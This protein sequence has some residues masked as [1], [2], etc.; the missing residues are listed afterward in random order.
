MKA[1]ELL[2]QM[3]SRENAL[4]FFLK[5]DYIEKLTN[6]QIFTL[7]N[8][9]ITLEYCEVNGQ[10]C[11]I[12][13]RAYFVIIPDEERNCIEILATVSNGDTRSLYFT[14]HGVQAEKMINND[15]VYSDV[16]DYMEIDE[17]ELDIKLFINVERM[18]REEF[19][20]RCVEIGRGFNKKGINEAFRSLVNY[21]VDSHKDFI[22]KGE[23]RD[24]EYIYNVIN[25]S[26][27]QSYQLEANKML[28]LIY[29]DYQ[30][31][32]IMDYKEKK[33]TKDFVNT[34]FFIGI[35]VLLVVLGSIYLEKFTNYFLKLDSSIERVKLLVFH[36]I[37]Y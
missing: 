14:L 23:Q 5:K 34:I 32:L 25:D 3:E 26:T 22:A 27:L 36:T 10:I 11:D 8:C 21:I 31:A 30:I 16:Y 9:E 24:E 28:E 18:S 1:D 33:K 37:F 12:T 6:K 2:S 35:I 4:S 20:K 13:N 15:E 7:K 17:D 19:A 29:F